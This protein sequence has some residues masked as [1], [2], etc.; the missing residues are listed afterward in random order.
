AILGNLSLVLMGIKESDAPFERLVAAKRASLRAQ[1]LA[2]QLLTFAKGGAPIKQTASI[3]QL[4]RETVVFHLRG[5]KV[6]CE[7]G[8][9]ED[10]GAAEVEAG[11]INQV[12]QNLTIN[13]HQA[14]PAGGS[15][16]VACANV[17]LRH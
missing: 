7:F 1:D 17:E 2:Q 3:A 15:L 11:Q 8:F 5:S 16:W 9:P 4:L 12:I 13:A 6:G 10:P 14:M